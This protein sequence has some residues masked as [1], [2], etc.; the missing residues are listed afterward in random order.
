M[1]AVWFLSCA[2]SIVPALSKMQAVSASR[3]FAKPQT[4]PMKIRKHDLRYHHFGKLQSHHLKLLE[5]GLLKAVQH[6]RSAKDLQGMP[7]LVLA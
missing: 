4:S 6:F 3:Q 1:V 2:L 5:S 7:I